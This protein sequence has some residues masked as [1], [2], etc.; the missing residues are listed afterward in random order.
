MTALQVI[1][2]ALAVG[3]S[4]GPS[5]SGWDCVATGES[6]PGLRVEV[7]VGA[8][9][10]LLRVTDDSHRRADCLAAWVAWWTGE[11]LHSAT[12][13]SPPAEFEAAYHQRLPATTEAA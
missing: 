8:K 2:L 3:R 7:L 12:H 13:D 10:L 6:R 1:T 4:P 5:P 11:R 9:S